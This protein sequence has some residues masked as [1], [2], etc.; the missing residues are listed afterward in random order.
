MVVRFERRGDSV[1]SEEDVVPP[2]LQRLKQTMA[3]PIT[4]MVKD[5]ERRERVF[6]RTEN[7]IP[8][9]RRPRSANNTSMLQTERDFLVLSYENHPMLAAAREKPQRQQQQQQRSSSMAELL[10]SLTNMCGPAFSCSAPP[11]FREEEFS[12]SSKGVYPVQRY[13]DFPALNA[14]H[15]IQRRRQDQQHKLFRPVSDDE[16]FVPRQL[17]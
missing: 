13:S 6:S 10:D 12:V 4:I 8:L 1:S 2:T 11:P 14:A 9:L 7:E 3:D 15:L 16:S 17:V 5:Q